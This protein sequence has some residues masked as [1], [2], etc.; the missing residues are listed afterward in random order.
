[1][2]PLFLALAAAAAIQAPS[3]APDA[4]RLP[5]A[6]VI[7]VIATNARGQA[8]ETLKASDFVLRENGDVQAIPEIDGAEWADISYPGFFAELGR[9]TADAVQT[10]GE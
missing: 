8:V 2:R 5:D 6:V 4:S 10:V 3:P 1:M 7:D 9:S